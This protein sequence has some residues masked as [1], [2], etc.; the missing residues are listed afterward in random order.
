[1]FLPSSQPTP[2]EILTQT[3]KNHKNTNTHHYYNN[4]GIVVGMV[5]SGSISENYI[6]SNPSISMPPP[7]LPH[8][9]RTWLQENCSYQNT[10][11]INLDIRCVLCT[12]MELSIPSYSVLQKPRTLLRW[13]EE[14]IF[15]F[16]L[17]D[18]FFFC[19]VTSHT[20][21]MDRKTISMEKNAW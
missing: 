21:H 18:N 10:S 19:L 1:M 20:A 17:L 5:Q 15:A 7:P 14:H 11:A 16:I 3:L 8:H 6:T 13:R 2:H 12:H 9:R 4:L